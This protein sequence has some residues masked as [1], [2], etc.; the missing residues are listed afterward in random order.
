MKEPLVPI[1]MVTY[2][3]LKFIGVSLKSVS[4]KFY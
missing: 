4:E 1:N 2:N 3:G